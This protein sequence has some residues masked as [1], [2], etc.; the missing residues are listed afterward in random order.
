MNFKQLQLISIVFIALSLSACGGGGSTSSTNE[1]NE[2]ASTSSSNSISDDSVDNGKDKKS[3][4]ADEIAEE[5]PIEEEPAASVTILNQPNSQTLSTTGSVNFTVQVDSN[6]PYNVNWYKDGALVSQSG[7]LQFES[8]T[9]ANSGTYSCEVLAS[10]LSESCADFVLTVLEP[11]TVTNSPGNQMITEGESVMLQ[12]SADGSDLNYQWYHNGELVSGATEAQL[13][14]SG[15]SLGEAGEYYCVVSNAVG[16][17]TSSTANLN[18]LEAVQLADVMITWQAPAERADGSS[19]STNE[20]SGFR[21]YYG[22]SSASGFTD[23]I[24]VEGDLNETTIEDLEQGDYKF[25][26]STIDTDGLESN[27]S[28]EFLLAIN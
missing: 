19:L 17:D 10:E 9:I 22:L 28:G 20:I 14:I 25:S 23:S 26:V 6:V 24:E 16:N 3:D 27:L 21:I 13:E 12:V 1:S 18:V 11:P 2:T 8:L 15:A 5:D 7:T 4:A